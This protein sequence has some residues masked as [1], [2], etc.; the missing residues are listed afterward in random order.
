MQRE[1]PWTKEQGISWTKKQ[2]LFLGSGQ[3][4]LCWKIY[5][6][7][8]SNRD[9]LYQRIKHKHHSKRMSQSRNSYGRMHVRY[10][11]GVGGG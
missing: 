4:K 10:E 8:V 2:A 7:I 3:G 6:I 1:L 11:Y 9:K 5:N